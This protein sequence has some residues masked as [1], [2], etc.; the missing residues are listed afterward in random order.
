MGALSKNEISLQGVRM[1]CFDAAGEPSLLQDGT[2]AQGCDTKR[3]GLCG[4]LYHK[5]A[6]LTLNDLTSQNPL[7]SAQIRHAPF[8]PRGRENDIFLEIFSVCM[9]SWKCAFAAEGKNL[10]IKMYDLGHET[11]TMMEDVKALI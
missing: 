11:Q 7:H 3:W 1:R 6:S 2:R 9:L 8:V 5:H 4:I 10:R